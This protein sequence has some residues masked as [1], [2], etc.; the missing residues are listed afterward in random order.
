MKYL[1]IRILQFVYILLILNS[2]LFAVQGNKTSVAIL[3]FD[4][5]NISEY[6]AAKISNRLRT[7]LFETKQFLLMDW[8]LMISVLRDKGFQQPKR[9]PISWLL[10]AGQILRVERIIGGNIRKI[11]NTYI[12]TIHFLD[13]QQGKALKTI[14]E[15][16]TGEIDILLHRVIPRVANQI[17]L[18]NF[19]GAHP[20]SLKKYYSNPE[21]D[22]EPSVI[23][24]NSQKCLK[25]CDVKETIKANNFFDSG[26]NKKG[27]GISNNFEMQN[28]N[29]NLVVIDYTTGLMWQRSGSPKYLDYYSSKEWIEELNSKRFAGYNDWRLPTLEEGMSL[30]EPK[31]KIGKLY[32]DN[33]F[34]RNQGW[35]WTCDLGKYKYEAWIVVFFR[36][37][38][39][40]CSF[41]R[42]R[43]VR[44]VRSLN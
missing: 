25:V 43:Y 30:L 4:V 5:Q 38:C 16:F 7:E 9:T 23:L 8:E 1:F 6:D 24:R 28:I 44:A 32:I 15:D 33:V 37:Y 21:M 36:G 40:R 39:D 20:D 27:K 3:N 2:Y 34:D 29:G 22:S 10:G 26:W 11:G 12:L 42:L 13:I 35:I 41:Q 19:S 31:M 14:T 18:E 17:V